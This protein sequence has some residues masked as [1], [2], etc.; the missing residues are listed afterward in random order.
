VLIRR[1]VD[2]V[3]N[4]GNLAA[5]PDYFERSL[6]DYNSVWVPMWRTALPDVRMWVD[7]LI[8][9]GNFVAVHLTLRGTHLG[10]LTSELIRDF[11]APL[12]PTGRRVEAAAMVVYEIVGDRIV[13]VPYG[14]MDW[15][16]LLRQLG[17]A[18]IYG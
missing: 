9:E 12:P 7:A 14:L 2:E 16:T 15:L 1:Y 4:R 10:E 13:R 6:A 17:A 8:A 11:T 3:W 18:S 5:I